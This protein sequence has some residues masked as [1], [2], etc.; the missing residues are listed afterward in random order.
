MSKSKRK[1]TED[2]ATT[3]E[4]GSSK[5]LDKDQKTGSSSEN[6]SSKVNDDTSDTLPT[7]MPSFLDDID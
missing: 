7:E 6:I 1:R 4:I 3:E 2:Y 5:P